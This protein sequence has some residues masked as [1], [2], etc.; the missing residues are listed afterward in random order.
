MLLRALSMQ[1]SCQSW[2]GIYIASKCRLS[3]REVLFSPVARE[4][5]SVLMA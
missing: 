3:L 1:T 5:D 4:R 2:F